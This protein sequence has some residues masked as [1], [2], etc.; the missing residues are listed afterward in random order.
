MSLLTSLVSYWK[1]DEASGNALDAHGSNDLTDNNTVGAGTGIINN[2]RDFDE[3]S[4]E[5]FSKSD[6]ADLSTGDIDFTF[7]AWIKPET[8]AR[9]AYDTVIA[10]WSGSNLEYL[11]YFYETALFA[12]GGQSKKVIFAVSND[13]SAS[14]LVVASTFGDLSAGTWY[15]V[16]GWHDSVNNQIGISVNAGTADTA[17]H[18]TGVRDGTA[19]FEIGRNVDDGSG[20]VMNGLVDEV[21]F[22][23]RVL[24]SGERTSLY[25][26]GSG[27]PYSSF[28][29]GSFQS[30]WARNSNVVM[31]ASAA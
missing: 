10:K 3:A 25:N 12:P 20:G 11:L 22:W 8:I 27:L 14:T 30:A 19:T 15:C 16:H 23:K 24:T 18:T 9:N 28:G 26:G 2:G 17:A 7:Q 1:L 6:N 4:R 31:G 13:G 5:Y 21:G 29:G